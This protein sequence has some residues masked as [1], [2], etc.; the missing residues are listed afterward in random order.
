MST[1][2]LTIDCP[3]EECDDVYHQENG[4]IIPFKT[5]AVLIGKAAENI[6]DLLEM[7]YPEDCNGQSRKYVEGDSIIQC[8]QEAATEREDL[9]F[10][11]ELSKRISGEEVLAVW[12]Y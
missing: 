2:T 5:V 12:Q 10:A 9:K 1:I 8:L 7:D 6:I 4:G 11:K 3:Q